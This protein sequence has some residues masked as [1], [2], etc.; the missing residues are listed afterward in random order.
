MRKISILC[1][2]LIPFSVFWVLEW[3]A[4]RTYDAKP[5]WF[6]FA[7]RVAETQHIDFIFIGSSI[8]AA[9]VDA[10]T[11]VAEFQNQTG[12]RTVALNLG[13]GYTTMAE[14]YI[15]LRRLFR[16]HPDNLKGCVVILSAAEG[17]PVADTWEIPWYRSARPGYI[18]PYLCYTDILKAWKCKLEPAVKLNLTSL[19]LTKSCSIISNQKKIR[20][21]ILRLGESAIKKLFDFQNDVKPH[22]K[23]SSNRI[24]AAADVRMD[25]FAIERVREK[26]RQ[27]G[28]ELMH[29]QS[30]VNNWGGT[31]LADLI[32]LVNGFDGK[33]ILLKIPLSSVFS[34]VYQTDT[35]K[36]NRESLAL[37]LRKWGVPLLK[38]GIQ[39]C[40]EDFPDLW[41][42]RQSR[43]SEFTTKLVH[44]YL[45]Q[46]RAGGEIT[47]FSLNRLK[48]E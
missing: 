15:G 8:I 7:E 29:E 10:E 42:L 22:R 46:V 33:I 45:N 32:K 17:L 12:Q 20:A 19:W 37:H 1:A 40:D 18:Q 2:I 5:V 38:T 41:H 16:S 14:Y 24:A 44:A 36:Q 13:R 23:S 25:D 39:V 3:Y 21:G 26:A 27:L 28:K 47:S 31:V 4:S 43:M 30:P 48:G 6:A 35:Q 11:F 9:A 34:N